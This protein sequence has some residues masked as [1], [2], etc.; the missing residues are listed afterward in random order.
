[1]NGLSL[2]KICCLQERCCIGKVFSEYAKKSEDL[3]KKSTLE[4]KVTINGP[5]NTS[6][7][8]LKLKTRN[9][10]AKCDSN[11]W[12]WPYESALFT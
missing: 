1:M 10:S 5:F 8:L 12:R 6:S 2:P 3:E 11:S 4:C 9:D 7:A